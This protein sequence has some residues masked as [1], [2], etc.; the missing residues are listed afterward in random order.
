MNLDTFNRIVQNQLIR[1]RETLDRKGEEYVFGNDR[2]EHFKTSATEQDTTPKQALWSMASKHST[3]LAAMCKSANSFPLNLW[4]E[5][6][7]DLINYCLLLMALVFEENE[8][9]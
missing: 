7:G 5:K 9:G 2:L 4:Q 3:S 1:C 6:A 8:N